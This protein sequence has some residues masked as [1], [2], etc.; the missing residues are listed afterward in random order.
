MNV[1]SYNN[2]DTVKARSGCVE[3]DEK[4]NTMVFVA[5]VSRF[6]YGVMTRDQLIPMIDNLWPYPFTEKGLSIVKESEN[7]HCQ[8]NN[9]QM[10]NIFNVRGFL[11]IFRSFTSTR[12][13]FS[14]N[15]FKPVSKFLNK[16]CA[17][18]LFLSSFWARSSSNLLVASVI[19]TLDPH[20]RR[21]G[22]CIYRFDPSRQERTSVH[23]FV[24][25]GNRII[26]VT[27]ALHSHS[28]KLYH[29]VSMEVASTVNLSVLVSVG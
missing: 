12:L 15:Y 8:T 11:G 3:H 4:C 7:K 14:C 5:L 28:Y 2:L 18:R 26:K 1:L 23:K 19:K 6:S 20:K 25:S 21:D 24:K 9:N 29:T 16:M 22:L 17:M 27:K 13:F 10:T